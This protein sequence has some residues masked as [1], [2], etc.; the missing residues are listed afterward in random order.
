MP[1][2]RFGPEVPVA[3]LT[4]SFTFSAA[5]EFAY[6]LQTQK[7]ATLIGET[8]GGGAHP[9]TTLRLHPTL[10]AHVPF[11]RAVNPLTGTNWEGTGVQPDVAVP[12]DR[13]LEE[14]ERRLRG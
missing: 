5:E 11:Q 12:A 9:I 3:V 4:S 13:A 7:R 8:T 1:G 10:V 2:R 14:A 6:N